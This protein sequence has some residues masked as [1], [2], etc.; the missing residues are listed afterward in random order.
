MAVPKVAPWPEKIRKIP[1]IKQKEKQK[2]GIFSPFT[3]SDLP[4]LSFPSPR[5]M[6]QPVLVI[7]L[8]E[9]LE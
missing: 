5:L 8:P 2:S 7:A 1:I 4:L 6:E 3:N 9:H